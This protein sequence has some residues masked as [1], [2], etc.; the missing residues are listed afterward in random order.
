MTYLYL[1]SSPRHIYLALGLALSEPEAVHHLR[2]INQKNKV[3]LFVD[4]AKRSLH[5]FASVEVMP[6]LK[7]RGKYT[8]K[9]QALSLIGAWLE[10]NSADKIFCGNDRS[11]EFQYAMHLSLKRGRRTQGAYLDDGTGSYF[12]G[13]YLRWSRAFTDLTVDRC[14]KWLFYGSWYHKVRF[15]GGTRWVSE[16]YL[17][18]PELA[19]EFIKR[20]K[21]V[22]PLDPA[23][24]RSEG[25]LN[26]LRALALDELSGSGGDFQL[27]LVLPLSK[28][29]E[30]FYTG[31]EEYLGLVNR[32]TGDYERIAVKYH[33]RETHY[34]FTSDRSVTEFPPSLPAEAIFSLVNVDCVIG[35]TSSA[36]LSAQWLNP[37]AKVICLCPQE[38]LRNPVIGLMQATRI[39]V[40]EC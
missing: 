14:M 25:F 35:D 28:S 38:L 24:F 34:Y 7:K 27:F 9:K 29:I 22:I 3:N 37:E 26:A 30:R 11:I 13:C 16:C 6:L 18:F 39:Q 8:A 15:L 33:P 21:K 36:L 19:P 4:G 10:S 23:I 5:P 2:I 17:S 40:Q 32:L 12:N 1:C 31:I 20:N